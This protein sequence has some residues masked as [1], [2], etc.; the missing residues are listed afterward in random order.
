M[1]NNEGIYRSKRY[2]NSIKGL[3]QVPYDKID[4]GET[5]YQAVCRK[6]REKMGL[7]TA[8]IYLI[9]DKGFNCDLYTTN[10]GKRIP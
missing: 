10:I 8:L 3:I 6:I 1:Y 4:S 7:Y 2:K 9:T 5:F